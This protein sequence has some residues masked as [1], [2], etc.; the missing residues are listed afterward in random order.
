MLG[1]PASDAD[2]LAGAALSFT[3]RCRIEVLLTDGQIPGSPGRS[4]AARHDQ[5]RQLPRDPRAVRV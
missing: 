4:H 2:P 1:S 3:E 5:R